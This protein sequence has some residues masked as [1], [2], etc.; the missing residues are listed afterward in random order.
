MKLDFS[1][2]IVVAHL[3][4]NSFWSFEYSLNLM[5]V[6]INLN[7]FPKNTHPWT[8]L[9]IPA[10]KQK[11][12][13]EKKRK[14]EVTHGITRHPS[15]WMLSSKFQWL[16]ALHWWFCRNIPLGAFVGHLS[17]WPSRSYNSQ[18]FNF[19]KGNWCNLIVLYVKTPRWMN[20]GKPF[21]CEYSLW[22]DKG[23][24]TS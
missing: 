15:K 12:E 20:F 8:S 14:K 6:T 7:F 2:L 17:L 13:K 9:V 5:Q 24:N 22:G 10:S 1:I 21:V 4:W 3:L 23:S 18:V 16:E 19:R 11:K